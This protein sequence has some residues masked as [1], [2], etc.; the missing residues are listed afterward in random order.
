[1]IYKKVQLSKKTDP[2]LILFAKA[3]F[4]LG[5]HVSFKKREGISIICIPE[6]KEIYDAIWERARFLKN[7]FDQELPVD[8]LPDGTFPDT[9]ED[10]LEGIIF[11][12]NPDLESKTVRIDFNRS[13]KSMAI[14]PHAARFIALMLNSSASEV[15]PSGGL[16][17]DGSRLVHGEIINE[18]GDKEEVKIQPSLPDMSF[19][20]G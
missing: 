14:Q 7:R 17:R 15:D 1:M 8:P 11:A 16:I 6:N 20:K 2:D 5:Y 13:V 19:F 10:L 4:Q 18:N 9:E 12:V 3:G